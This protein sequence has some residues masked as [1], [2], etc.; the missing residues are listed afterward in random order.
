[1]SSVAAG[2]GYYQDVFVFEDL[3]YAMEGRLRVVHVYRIIHKSLIKLRDIKC[4]CECVGKERIHS[5]VVTGDHIIQCCA[6]TK[7]VSILDRFGELLRK[8]SIAEVSGRMPILR[9]ADVEGNFLIADR[10]TAR[11]L[12]AHVDLPISQ[13]H[14]VSLPDSPGRVYCWGALWFRHRL[15]VT[16]HDGRLLSYTPVDATSA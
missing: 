6:K 1:M 14:V 2:G 8:I 3:V 5:I 4:P 10:V 11:L 12:I 15:Y 9:Q 16:D 7:L 13:W